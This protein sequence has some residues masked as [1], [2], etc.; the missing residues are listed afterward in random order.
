MRNL[1]LPQS[2]VRLS[3]RSLLARLSILTAAGL[4]EPQFAARA[5]AGERELG[6]LAVQPPSAEGSWS[7]LKVDGEIPRDLRGT[8]CRVAPGQKVN[9]GV[10]L[11]HFFDG[12]AF[13][14]QY[15]LHEGQASVSARFI[16]TPE[17]VEETDAGKML[18]NE[19]G[20]TAP[21]NPGR[22][23]KNQPSINVIRWDG[24]L[25]A[26]SEGGHPS[27]V[28]PET[29]AFQEHWDFHGTL[30]KDVSF[31]AHPKFDPVTGIG[32]AF[33]THQGR[34]LA[35]TVYRME[36]DGR[37]TQLAALP[38][39]NY[40]M[41]HDMLMGSEYLVLIV[42]P[43]HYDLP[44][45]L[46]GRV[47]SAE[48]L[49][50][51]ANE[52]T[53]LIIL[54][55][56]G[57]GAPITIEQPAAM[58]FHH[59]N[60]AESGDTLTIDS[61]FTPDDSILRYI[62]AWSTD[63][64]PA[65]KPTELTRL[66]LDLKQRQVTSRSVFGRDQEFPRFDTRVSGKPSRYLYTLEVGERFSLQ[67]LVRHD[68]AANTTRRVEA[69]QG[70]AY[71]EAVFAP[72]SGKAGEDEGWILHQGYSAIRNETFLDIRDAATLDRAARVW[73]GQHF[74]VGFHGNFYTDI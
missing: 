61:V 42:P 71:E 6:R 57:T 41:V 12:D 29:L 38:Q 39:A 26:L 43:V 22:G 2:D 21:G 46:S 20:T 7:G 18:Y 55:K 51:A 3:R 68:F 34:D 30:P 72:K 60:L 65:P 24:R 5:L 59:G 36:L 15:Q 69:D 70:H 53:R 13:L 17:R 10:Q 19:F 52:P 50:Y 47:A 73:T 49:R 14:I 44:T 40:F 58:V 63:N 54:R 16:A 64:P 67:S 45:L 33:G 37:L 56:D 35:L 25:L 9:H 32:Y 48:A 66:T 1:L 74:P 23:G 11:R 8:L 62:A 28:D 31:T 4:V 27:A